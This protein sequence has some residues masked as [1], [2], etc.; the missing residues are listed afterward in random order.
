MNYKLEIQKIAATGNPIISDNFEHDK[1][2]RT[3]F[4]K[5]RVMPGLKTKTYGLAGAMAGAT[6]GAGLGLAGKKLTRAAYRK[7]FS[8]D[9]SKQIGKAFGE[10]LKGSHEMASKIRKIKKA[11][12]KPV[13]FLVGPEL[14]KAR[15]LTAAGAGA[16]A[17]A[18]T[19]KEIG[20]IVGNI[21]ALNKQYID[22]FGIEPS[23]DDIFKA[24]KLDPER[25]KVHRSM[26]DFF[27]TPNAMTKSKFREQRQIQNMSENTG[28]SPAGINVRSK[29]ANE[30]IQEIEK[31]AANASTIKKALPVATGLAGAAFTAVPAGMLASSV[32]YDDD[33][34]S[35]LKKG[36]IMA[37]GATIGGT[38][39]T[40]IGRDIV[41][42]GNGIA[43]KVSHPEDTVKK[44]GDILSDYKFVADR[45]AQAG[46][47]FVRGGVE[48]N[49]GQGFTD[50][51]HNPNNITKLKSLV[52]NINGYKDMA[53]KAYNAGKQFMGK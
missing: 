48:G 9:M 37:G 13:K 23:E 30:Y 20:K 16:L 12:A 44:V 10:S 27:Y 53:G 19:G 25:N 32:I 26:A 52:R 6:V 8:S 39:G 5:D 14:A 50:M 7:A 45:A 29:V 15:A 31:V 22:Q 43:R 47:A 40:T 51:L 42:I 49:V 1:S 4:F 28:I 34:K 24:T 46:K 21:G 3:T 36:A 11:T 41:D 33:K 17:F 35:K 2:D 18:P 38:I